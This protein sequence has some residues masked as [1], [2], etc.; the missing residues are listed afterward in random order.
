MRKS[1]DKRIIAL[2]NLWLKQ[3]PHLSVPG[4]IIGRVLRKEE[5]SG[6][7]WALMIGPMSGAYPKSEF[8]GNTIEDCVLRAEKSLSSIKNRK[9]EEK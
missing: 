2:E 3:T 5:G 6:W 4:T 8:R 9:S 1:L 7:E